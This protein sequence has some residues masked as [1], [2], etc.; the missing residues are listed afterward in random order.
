MIEKSKRRR[1]DFSATGKRFFPIG[2]LGGTLRRVMPE[3]DKM[4]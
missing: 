1:R 4:P 2:R 3:T